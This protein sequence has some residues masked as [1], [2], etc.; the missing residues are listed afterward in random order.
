MGGPRASVRFRPFSP[1]ALT[2]TRT[3]FILCALM[4]LSSTSRCIASPSEWPE[5]SLPAKVLLQN[6]GEHLSINGMPTR[7]LQF[8]SALPVD[9]VIAAFRRHIQRDYTR[10]TGSTDGNYVVAGRIDDF[11]LT[12]QLQSTPDGGTRGTWSAAPR[13]RE[14]AQQSV[15]RPPGFPVGATLIQQIDSFD[16]DKNSQLAIGSDTASIH[17]V[18]DRLESTLRDA[19]YKKDIWPKRSW[20]SEDRYAAVFTRAR[21]QVVVTLVPQAAGTAIVINRITAL[22]TLQ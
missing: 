16:A 8:S 20:V 10:Q 17:G 13:F 19:G 9:E 2:M 6:V 4:I 18:A 14:S 21:E 12:L 3:V 15:V 22:E 11:W 7:I 1:A 5:P